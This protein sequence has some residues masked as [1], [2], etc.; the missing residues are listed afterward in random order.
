MTFVFFFSPEQRKTQKTVK[1]AKVLFKAFF[2]FGNS[3][4]APINAH[5]ETKAPPLDRSCSI[6][7]H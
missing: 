1:A 3:R 6:S 7:P 5:L 4:Q 2:S